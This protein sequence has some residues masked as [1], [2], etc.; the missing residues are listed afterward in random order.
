MGKMFTDFDVH[1]GVHRLSL[2]SL[3]IRLPLGYETLDSLG[4]VFSLNQLTLGPPLY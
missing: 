3:K 4:E 1:A 2:S